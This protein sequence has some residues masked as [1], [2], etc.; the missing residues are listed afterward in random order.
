MK[1][2]EIL[3][4]IEDINQKLMELEDQ[5]DELITA[6]FRMEREEEDRKT[7]AWAE[8]VSQARQKNVRVKEGRHNAKFSKLNFFKRKRQERRER[9]D[10]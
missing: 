4:T 6:K 2:E 9:L 7:K 8:R 5:R 1:K 10:G 3:N